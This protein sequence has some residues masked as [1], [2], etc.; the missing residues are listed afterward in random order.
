[1]V[2]PK[3]FLNCPRKVFP[4]IGSLLNGRDYILAGR[5]VCQMIQ[6]AI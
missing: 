4:K 6:L 3:D 2:E 5:F 1:M